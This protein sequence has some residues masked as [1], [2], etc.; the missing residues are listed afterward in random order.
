MDNSFHTTNLEVHC[1][2]RSSVVP[3]LPKSIEDIDFDLPEYK[4]YTLTSESKLF[5]QYDNKKSR[6]RK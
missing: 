2:V 4:D 1:G 3:V 5:L 6:Y